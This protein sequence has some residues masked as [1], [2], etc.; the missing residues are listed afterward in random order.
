MTLKFFPT[1]TEFR[2]WLEKN[3]KTE[4]RVICWFLQSSQ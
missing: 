2:Q 3:H 4:N 1:Q